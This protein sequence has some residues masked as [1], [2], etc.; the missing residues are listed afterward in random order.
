MFNMSQ[1]PASRRQIGLGQIL[2][3]RKA[4][5]HSRNSAQVETK[6]S[7]EL[8]SPTPSNLGLTIDGRVIQP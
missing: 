8:N 4:I 1:L 7:S 3:D 5:E 6:G 2:R